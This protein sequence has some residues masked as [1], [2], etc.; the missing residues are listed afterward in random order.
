VA[1]EVDSNPKVDSTHIGVSAKSL[2]LAE[3][4]MPRIVTTTSSELTANEVV[5]SFESDQSPS[6]T[7][8]CS[9]SSTI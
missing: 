4:A 3:D 7:R 9:S 6:R 5:V 2:G 1:A 8:T